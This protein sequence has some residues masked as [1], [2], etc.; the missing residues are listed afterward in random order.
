[1]Y[2]Y[3]DLSKNAGTINLLTTNYGGAVPIDDPIANY[4]SRKYNANFVMD[5]VPNN[6]L[7]TIISTRFAAGDYPDV[8]I[9]NNKRISQMLYDQGL[10]MD[11]TL[12]MRYMPNYAR[13]FTK[14]YSDIFKY[15]DGYSAAPR[16]PI[17]GDWNPFI[18]RDWLKTLGMSVPKTLDELYTYAQRVTKE[19]PDRNGRNDTYFAGGGGQGFP[20]LG[21]I[22][23][24]FGE[25]QYNAKNG[26]I[27][28][29]MLDGSTKAWLTYVKRLHDEGLLMPD[30]YVVNWTE[31]G[32]MLHNDKLGYAN[33]PAM[34]LIIEEAEK[35]Y[36]LVDPTSTAFDI[37]QA[38]PPI[39]TGKATPT[40]GPSYTFVFSSSLKNDPVKLKRIAH[41]LD[42]CLYKG[43]DYYEA[44]QNGGNKVW[45]SESGGR[46]FMFWKENP[47]GSTYFWFDTERKESYFV[48]A[49]SFDV[50]AWQN[51]GLAGPPWRLVYYPNNVPLSEALAR[52]AVALNSFPKY[53]SNVTVQIDPEVAEPLNEFERIELPKFIFGGRDINNWD[54]YLRDWLAAGGRKALTQAARQMGVANFE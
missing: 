20:M 7:E 51:I 35:K 13:Y 18:R 52:E 39:G 14:T 28:H 16:Y 2:T 47:D 22:Q 50:L 53:V 4:F 5:A 49:Q 44:I 6:D 21:G 36:A 25:M 31:V 30:W 15:K 8:M 48:D 29:P 23:W 45:A 46:D 27:N 12:P 40:S 9:I 34:E 37:W 54:A 11:A 3:D 26:K 33:Y 10:V 38:L 1:M 24:Y 17:Q 42:N 43:E 32:G 41:F 19:D